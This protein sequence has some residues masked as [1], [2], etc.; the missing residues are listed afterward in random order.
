[1]Q[2]ICEFATE[3]LKD[4]FKIFGRNVAKRLPNMDII[5]AVEHQAEISILLS[6]V[7]KRLPN[8]DII[9]AVE[10]QAEISILLSKARIQDIKDKKN[11]N[12]TQISRLQQGFK[13]LKTRKT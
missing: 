13:I 10:H 3:F 7:A 4:K 12:G 9:R 11:V 5:R 2:K 8:M 6:K 1:M